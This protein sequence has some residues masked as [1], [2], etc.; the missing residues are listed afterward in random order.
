MRAIPALAFL[1][2]LTGPLVP[3]HAEVEKICEQ[4]DVVRQIM[5]RVN[6]L[7][8]FKARG[9]QAI[10]MVE[11][12]TEAFDG[13]TENLTCTFLARWSDLSEGRVR[14]STSKNSL[15]QTILKVVPVA[16]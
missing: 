13:K 11:P 15:G 16:K 7:P 2:V 8:T 3:A 1:V 4:P 6:M 5:E 10:D 9:F 14:V 12:K